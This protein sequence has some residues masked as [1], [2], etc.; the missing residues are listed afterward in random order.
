MFLQFRGGIVEIHELIQSFH[1]RKG[2]HRLL[3]YRVTELHS[4]QIKSEFFRVLPT[5][6]RP[7]YFK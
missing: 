2:T 4:F 1:I 6:V 5:G 3:G 7:P